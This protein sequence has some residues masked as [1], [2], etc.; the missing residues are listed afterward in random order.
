[1]LVLALAAVALGDSHNDDHDDDDHRDDDH[2]DDDEHD[3]DDHHDDHDQDDN[4]D[5]DDH[6]DFSEDYRDIDHRLDKLTARLEH[7]RD[8]IHQ[9]TN[10][11][12]IQRA[13]SLRS[14]VQKLEGKSVS[15][16]RIL[17]FN[18]F[19]ICSR[20]TIPYYKT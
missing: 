1:M 12:M 9:R 16:F 20:M 18:Y 11:H 13:R 2:H 19:V 3:D 8:R 10:P 17:F 7:I 5:D 6:H 4:H 15:R 14:R